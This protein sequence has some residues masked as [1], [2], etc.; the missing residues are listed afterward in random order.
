MVSTRWL[1]AL[2]GAAALA[3][4]C[5]PGADGGPAAEAPITGV[6][7]VSGE[8]FAEGSGDR[9]DISGR[10]VIEEGEGGTYRATFQLDTTY[11]GAEEALPAELIGMGQGRIEGRSLTGSAETQLVMATVPGVDPGFAFVPRV[12][13]TRLDATSTAEVSAAGDL[14]LELASRSS[15][16]ESGVP[17]RITLHGSRVP[18]PLGVAAGPPE[19]P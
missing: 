15:G 7:E 12:V 4:A 6:Y 1:A 5:G 18:D 17:D 3:A 10:V 2:L 9:R 19:L 14:R 16:G 11:P 8:T 13:S